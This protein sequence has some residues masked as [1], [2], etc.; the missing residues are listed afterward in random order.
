[1]DNHANCPRLGNMYVCF[2]VNWET[3]AFVWR[4]IVSHIDRAKRF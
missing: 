4:W 3:I 1:M 2:Y